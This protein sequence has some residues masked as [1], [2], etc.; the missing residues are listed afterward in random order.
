MPSTRNCLGG[1]YHPSRRNA[2]AP[3][4]RAAENVYEE[5]RPAGQPF[6]RAIESSQNGIIDVV[7]Q[8]ETEGEI[9]LESD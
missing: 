6:M 2:G 8:L 7:R 1:H 5:I 4:K 9:S 3:S